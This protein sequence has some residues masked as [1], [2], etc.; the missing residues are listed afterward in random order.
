MTE[1]EFRATVKAQF[2]HVKIRIRTVSF[3]DLARC[4]A[5]CLTVDGDRPG[6][7]VAIN[8]LARDAGIT[9]DGNIRSYR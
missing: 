4:S 3:E 2:P 8:D 5:K 6:E 7:I 9:P 1:K